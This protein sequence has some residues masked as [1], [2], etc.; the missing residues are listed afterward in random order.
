MSENSQIESRTAF[1]NEA[2]LM[3]MK[4]LSMIIIKPMCNDKGL[5]LIKVSKQMD[6]TPYFVV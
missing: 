3:L 2:N 1:T 6:Y 5:I 4:Q